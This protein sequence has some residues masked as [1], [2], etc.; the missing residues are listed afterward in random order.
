MMDTYAWNVIARATARFNQGNTQRYE[1]EIE[2]LGG[3]AQFGGIPERR[4]S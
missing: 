3:V 2:R 4:S 1:Q